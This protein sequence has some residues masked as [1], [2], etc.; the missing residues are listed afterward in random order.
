MTRTTKLLPVV[1]FLANLSYGIPRALDDSPEIPKPGA[2]A[3]ALSFTN[4]LQVPDGAKVDW[5]SLKGKVV[6]LEF[7]A[8]WCAPCI[9]EIPVLNNLAK[10]VDP[11]KV[12]IISID[13]EDP[14]LVQAFIQKHP[15]SGWI[16]IDTS[17]A[18]LKRFGVNGRP[19]T[20]VVDTNGVV[21][22]NN[23]PPQQLKTDQ[24]IA[25]AEGKRVKLGGDVDPAVQAAIDEAQAKAFAE[26]AAPH[27]TSA[28]KSLV[29]ITL[30]PAEPAK[31][32]AN[33]MI[34]IMRP[35]KGKLDITDA[36]LA[37]ILKNGAKAERIS[38]DLPK[39]T[40]NLHVEAPTADEA[41]LAKTIELAV[42]SGTGLRIEHQTKTT[43][44]YVLKATEHAGDH[45]KDAPGRGGAFL[46]PNKN[47]QCVVADMDGVASALENALGKP[48]VNET[49]LT[50]KVTTK[51]TLD[52][53]DLT[54]VNVIL[55][56][57]LGLTLVVAQRPIESVLVSAPR[58]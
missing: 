38:G 29:E 58:K 12:Q 4:L 6:V 40:Y 31:E 17:G 23:V 32:G 44:A 27:G 36:P 42:A 16:G 56:K 24:L 55:Q 34:H 22:S 13:D 39:G 51:F 26:Q 28:V 25:L 5:P 53:Q 46:D 7:W 54:A 45:I 2:Q 43:E 20:I 15:I 57:E 11:S 19:A 14:A 18:L 9:A 49:G 52:S 33:Q 48:V 30:T 3:P 35:G 1:L 41:I 37:V 47:F 21:A 10:A 50:G 8:T